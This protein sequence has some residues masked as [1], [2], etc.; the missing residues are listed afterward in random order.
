MRQSGARFGAKVTVDG[1]EKLNTKFKDLLSTLQKVR[2]ELNAINNGGQTATGN[3]ATNNQLAGMIRGFQGGGGG[4]ALGGFALGLGLDGFGAINARTNRNM[5]QS[6]GISATDA[7]FASMYGY[8]YRGQEMSRIGAMGQY[9]GSRES[10]L[11]AQT[12]GFNY[13]MM[14]DQNQR[15][16]AMAANVV[17]SYGGTIDASQAAALP[18][19]FMDPIHMRRAMALGIN[20]IRQSGQVGNPNAYGLSI[21]QNYERLRGISFNEAD[22]ANARNP[23]SALRY[24][25]MRR[26]SL[27]AAG[28]D[29]LINAGQQ[30]LTFRQRTGANRDINFNSSADLEAI[31][32]NSDVLGL[33]SVHLSSAVARREGSFFASNES[34]M[35]RRLGQEINIQNTLRDTEEGLSAVIGTLYQ[36]ENALKGITTV[37]GMVAPIAGAGMLMGGGG[38]GIGGGGLGAGLP[39]GGGKGLGGVGAMAR[40]GAGMVGLGLTGAGFSMA[41]S[42]HAFGGIGS[43]AAGG[44]G[45]GFM[46]GGP[47]GAAV[48]AAVGAVAGA[49]TS[50]YSIAKGNDSDGVQQGRDQASSMTDAELIA[51]LQSYAVH[52]RALIEAQ[53]RQAGPKERGRFDVWAARRG[54]LLSAMLSEAMTNGAIKPST[55]DAGEI[56]RLSMF[57]SSE[58]TSDD[59]AFN[60]NAEKVLKY[61][62]SVKEADPRL[63][64]KY[65]GAAEDPFSNIAVDTTE[66]KTLLRNS[67]QVYDAYMESGGSGDP[68]GRNSSASNLGR[69]SRKGIG[70]GNASWD[71]LDD[72]MKQRLTRLMAASGGRVW[73]GEG[74]RDPEGHHEEEFYKRHYEDPN[75]RIQY[76]GKRYTLRRGYAPL[77]PPGRSNHNIG[78]AADLQGDLTWLQQNAAK[79]GLKTFADVNNEPWH[80]QLAELANGFLGDGA[81]QGTGQSNENVSQREHPAG[82]AAAALSAGSGVNYDAAARLSGGWGGAGG[83]GTAA[84]TTAGDMGA[85]S[86]YTGNGPLSREDVARMA[87]R[88]GFRGQALIDVVAIAGR[89]SSYNPAAFNGNRATGDK[90]YGLMQINMIDTLGPARLRQFGIGSAEDLFDPQTNLN[91]AFMMYQQRGGSLYDWGNYKGMSNTYNTDVAA[92]AAAVARSGVGGDPVESSTRPTVRQGAADGTGSVQ[93][94]FGNI[95]IQSSGDA[96]YDANEFIRALTPQLEQAAGMLVKGGQE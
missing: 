89:E 66:Y 26:Y 53:G 51:S 47:K 38:G 58:K 50:F 78:L 22:F 20:P 25:L 72:R 69:Q 91:A 13:G 61:A 86:S 15:F 46:V 21:I 76:K 49:A 39:V 2:E 71:N 41:R 10:Q 34:A 84:S 60:D 8:S 37:I 6:I 29:Q 59:S 74:W 67:Q 17:Q 75:G 56:A 85:G 65:F 14:R 80:V 68:V 1:V 62:M 94:S 93:I 28:I 63:Y 36:F 55:R 87:Y 33:R 19:A 30:N 57:F 79:Y 24:D 40:G 35:N 12:I 5:A 83:L 43:M 3:S 32:L 27:D 18:G 73:V 23:G 54:A 4:M 9:G 45:I 16:L 77:A 92:A 81:D 88:A 42:G 44:A 11:A 96:K 52:G 64:A 82:I 7:R 95:V 48:G 70:P 31:G 90:S